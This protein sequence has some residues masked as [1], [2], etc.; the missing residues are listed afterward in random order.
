MDQ[1]KIGRFIAERRKKK[2][3]TQMQL[4]ERLGIA[5]RAISKW[6]NGKGMPDSSLMLDLC[7]ALEISVNELLSGEMIDMKEY[8]QKA[9]QQLLEMVKERE[10][11]DKELLHIEVFIGVLATIIL[12]SCIFVASFVQLAA[13]IRIVLISAGL[14]PFIIGV[15]YAVRL[16]QIAG[17]YECQRCHNK[18]VPTYSQVFFAMHSGRTRYMKCPECGEKSWQKKII[19]K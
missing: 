4:A 7:D 19:S 8:N 11:K 10:K 16:E 9:E 15:A 13:W 2:K 12:L 17:F 6:E 5:D 14:A 3:L 1:I 18:Y